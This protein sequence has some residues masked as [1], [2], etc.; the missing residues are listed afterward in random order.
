M[1]RLVSANVRR[2]NVAEFRIHGKRRIG[3]VVVMANYDPPSASKLTNKLREMISA[4]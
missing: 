4:K 2:Y 3:S 1:I